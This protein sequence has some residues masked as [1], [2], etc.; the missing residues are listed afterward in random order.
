MATAT[1]EKRVRALEAKIE[2]LEKTAYQPIP[3]PVRA[4]HTTGGKQIKTKKLPK[5]LQAS[6]KEAEEGKLIG[7]F[8]SVKEFMADL[9]R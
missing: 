9:K 6:L 1:L 4:T 5:W 3:I 2:V 7:P 8:H